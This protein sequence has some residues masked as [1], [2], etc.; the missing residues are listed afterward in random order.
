MIARPGRISLPRGR[1]LGLE[2]GPVVMGI[3]NVTPDS[4]YPLSRSRGTARA[5]EAALAMEA[6]GAAIVDLGGESTRP[7]SSYVDE[8]EELERVVPAVRAIRSRSDLPI[9]VDTRKASVAAAAIEAGA[10]MINDVSALRYD[11]AMAALAAE[12]GIALLLMHMKGEPGTMQDAPSYDDCASEVR[13][14]LAES[15]ARAIAAGVEPGRI[16]IDPGIG[17]G[18]R[19]EDNLAILSALGAIAGLGYPVAVGISRKAF[20]GGMVGKPVEGRLPAS[21]GAACAALLGGAVV[22]RVH[23]VGATVDA[24]A[25]FAAILGLAGRGSI[26]AGRSP[27]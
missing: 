19:L 5:A 20:L 15:A 14:F 1:S 7:G 3:I 11:P 4:F 8:A 16:L 13:D 12:T 2:S 26:P 10:D 27:A 6:E 25:V 24:L 18:K 23:D 22:F 9:S 17:F 21:L